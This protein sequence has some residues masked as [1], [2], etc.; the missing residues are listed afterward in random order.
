MSAVDKNGMTPLH[1]AGLKSCRHCI[2]LLLL[3]GCDVKARDANGS[4]RKS[5][6]AIIIPLVLTVTALHHLVTIGDPTS[7]NMLLSFGADIDAKDNEGL[8]RNI[9]PYYIES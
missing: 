6:V 9:E 5:L 7:A 2:N 1:D 8:V 4:T 3:L